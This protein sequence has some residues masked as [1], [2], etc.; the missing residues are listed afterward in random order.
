[1]VHLPWLV[2]LDLLIEQVYGDKGRSIPGKEKGPARWGHCRGSKKETS[3][4]LLL[5]VPCGPVG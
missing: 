5:R 4:K 3:F 1:M 2:T